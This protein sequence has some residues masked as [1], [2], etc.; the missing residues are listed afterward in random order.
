MEK[1]AMKSQLVDGLDPDEERKRVRKLWLTWA[2]IIVA[3]VALGAY[4]VH[5]APPIPH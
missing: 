2:A 4:A 1:A 5:I 3:I